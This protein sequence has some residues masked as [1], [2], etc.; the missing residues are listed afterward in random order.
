MNDLADALSALKVGDFQ[1]RWEVA[2]QIEGYGEVVLQPLLLLLADAD[3]ELQW[4]I[5]KLLGAYA[6]PEALLALV[7]LLET[8]E[9][10]EV[11]VIAAQSLAGMG[12]AAIAPL[13]P[14]LDDPQKAAI[15]IRALAQM[16]Q[17]DV[18]PLLLQAAQSPW[19]E[20][21]QGSLEALDRF[22]GSA[23]VPVLMA[24]LADP[25]PGVR[26]AAIAGL[27]T[28]PNQIPVAELVDRIAPCLDDPYGEVADQ[29][30]RAL[31]RLATES[32]AIALA[33]K[34]IQSTPEAALQTTLIQALGWIG[35]PPALKGLIQIWDVL[36]HQSP[37]PERLLHDVL[38]SMAR[39]SDSVAQADATQTLMVWMRSP[40]LQASAP[41]RSATVLAVGRLAQPETIPDWIDWLADPDY[42]VRLHVIAALKQVAADQAYRELVRRAQAPTTDPVLA[43]GW[44]IAMREWSV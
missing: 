15:A 14:Y 11:A 31:G 40:I 7:N 21:R 34:G 33:E 28:R 26:Q 13:A 8:T 25:S 18:V 12:V 37:L 10:E 1:A 30:A 39:I 6:H 24:G 22:Q 3:G 17:P 2:K 27:A 38:A 19:P 42:G 29:A 4:F 16:E 36:S 44:A 23:I 32:A 5:A 9:E 35:T 41:L 20:V 43:E